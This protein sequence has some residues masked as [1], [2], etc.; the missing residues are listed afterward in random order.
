MATI[1]VADLWNALLDNH[2]LEPAQLDELRTMSAATAADLHAV[3]RLLLQKGWLTHF[4]INYLVQGRAQELRLGPYLLLERLGEGG[5]GQVFKAHH[6]PMDRPVAL[7][8]IRREL[9]ARPD[10]VSR[11]YR[12]VRAAAKLVHPN[13]VLAYDAG[14]A[15]DSHFLAM[16]YVAGADLGKL[17]KQR[18]PLP[19]SEACTY[20]RQAALGLQHAHSRGF[21]HRDIKPSNLLLAQAPATPASDLIK[22]VDL[23]LARLLNGSDNDKTLTQEGT[24]LGTPAYVAPEQ[25]LN[26]RSAD[27]R[28]D[29][30]SL[31]CT[32]YQLLTGRTPFEADTATEMMLKHH[33]EAPVS[34]AT[35]RSDVPAPVLAILERLMAKRPEDRYETPAQLAEALT[36]A[37]GP[38]AP[39][40][41]VPIVVGEARSG[42]TE[43]MLS[44]K[45]VPVVVD[46]AALVPTLD[47]ATRSRLQARKQRGFLAAALALLVMTAGIAAALWRSAGS[48]TPVLD[49]ASSKAPPISSGR[50]GDDAKRDDAKPDPGGQPVR[51]LPQPEI[52]SFNK[53]SGPVTSV[54][55]AANGKQALS[56]GKDGIT[57]LWDVATGQE[58]RQFI[59]KG[60]E[61]SAVALA[62]N[63]KLAV[64]GGADQVVHVWDLA[65]GKELRGLKEHGAAITCLA[66][67]PDEQVV[68]SGDRGSW[69]KIW[70]L[71]SPRAGLGMS[72]PYGAV[73][74]VGFGPERNFAYGAAD[75]MVRVANLNPARPG[76]D[77]AGHKGKVL[78]VAFAVDGKHLASAGADRGIRLWNLETGTQVRC[79]D[80]HTT[81]VASVALSPNGRRLVSGG[82]MFEE[83]EGAPVLI[84]GNP[85]PT[86][87]GLRIWDVATG[88]QLG[89]LGNHLARITCVVFAPDGKSLL[90]ASEDGTVRLWH[91]PDAPSR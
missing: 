85:V 75:G 4:Q 30:Y 67:S 81:P 73:Y 31:G 89:V 69:L 52:R 12:E 18:G 83:K 50:V 66:T 55:F 15:G 25:V 59:T 46:R 7:K 39:P 80:G 87:C 77:L 1:S 19:V 36:G 43:S 40:A 35:Y 26:A 88:K 45:A 8:I 84:D 44:A 90:S 16:E 27:I 54:V 41:Q 33:L 79:F 56:G 53:H 9:L 14:Q 47:L 51:I 10:S 70:D 65:S 3:A 48:T 23:G 71:E 29:L 62:A 22:I 64:A 49:V 34:V 38:A 82:G 91:V 21:V 32:L 5:M 13:I 20:I 72:G 58:L 17:V 68:I 63:G 76:R 6:G 57:R 74:C 86:D 42:S 60:S 37:S 2:L 78:S 61:I 28:S 24:V 11:F